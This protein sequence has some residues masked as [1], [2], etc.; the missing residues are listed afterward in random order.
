ELSRESYFA[1]L[2]EAK[3]QGIPVAGH[4]PTSVTAAE[5]SDAGQRSLEH[6]YGIPSG[7]SSKESEFMEKETALWGP[8]KPAMRGILPV[9]DIK[10]MI[11][12]YDE[13][14]C[15]AL[16]AKFVKNN[17]FVDPSM[18]R[19]R[20][21]GVPATDPRVVKYFSPALREYSYPASRTAT[22]PNPAAA[23]ARRLAYEYHS[24]L[25]KEMQRSG[26]KMLVGT[27]D[28]FFGTSLHEELAEFVKAGLTP[29]EALQIATRN[30]AEYYGKL[31]SSGTVEKGK[32]ADL[33][34]LDANPLDSI[35]NTQKISTVMVNGRL[36]NRS[37]LDRLLAQVES[38]NHLLR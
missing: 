28:S 30:A 11:A 2:D 29:M 5:A 20:G 12:S 34:L 38:A 23:E 35:E 13:A 19:A 36:L 24:R 1:L 26:V 3:R 16:F 14:K 15:K 10:T 6:N 27:D 7:C 8:G 32:V 31:A 37:D 22:S 25:V 9:G 4:V 18:L 17:T 21:G 33:V